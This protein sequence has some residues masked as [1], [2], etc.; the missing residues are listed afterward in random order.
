MPIIVGGT[1]YYMQSVLFTNTILNSNS[2][3]IETKIDWAQMDNKKLHEHLQEIDPKMAHHWHYND[4]RK[5]LNSLNTYYKFDK[6]QHKMAD[7]NVQKK[8]LRF[9]TLILWPF[10]NKESHHILLNERVD[11]MIEVIYK[12][13]CRMD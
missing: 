8:E 12:L 9:N 2:T 5:I 13:K 7:E 4:R 11:F 3:D 1:M 10:I 6:Q